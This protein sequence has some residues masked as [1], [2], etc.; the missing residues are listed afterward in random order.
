MRRMNDTR[1]GFSL[2]ELLL[3]IFILGIGIISVAAIFPAGIAQQVQSR[4]DLLGP[5][6]AAQAMS[7]IRANVGQED[8]GTFEQFGLSEGD[9]RTHLPG[10]AQSTIPGDW[11][12]MRPSFLLA[13]ATVGVPPTLDSDPDPLHGAIDIFGVR[14]TRESEGF[15]DL[16]E[17]SNEDD[18][19]AY[20]TTSDL[21]SLT[22]GNINGNVGGAQRS[23]DPFFPPFDSVNEPGS[24]WGIPFNRS[25]YSILSDPNPSLGQGNVPPDHRVN[26]LRRG[27][28]EPL[29]TITQGERAWP[30]GA[31][32]PEYYWDCLFRRYQGR[33]QI[34]IFVYRVGF[35]GQEAKPYTVAAHTSANNPTGFWQHESPVPVRIDFAEE[36]RWLPTGANP[37]SPLDDLAIPGTEPDGAVLA[38]ALDPYTDGWQFPGQWIL[39]QH[40]NVHR[41]YKGRRS[42][43]DGPVRLAQ[44]VPYMPQQAASGN[45]FDSN[46]DLIEDPSEASAVK[47]IWFVPPETRDGVFLTPVF[48]MVKDL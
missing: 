42:P 2:V 5:V 14:R 18:E 11:G 8:F 21:A 28:A 4:D 29:R 10:D 30:Q 24:L 39:D 46:F 9:A 19:N 47:S 1:R 36:D 3:S 25:R 22:T 45:L 38:P 26:P 15:S 34:A 7:T 17:T 16:Q 43:A 27:R 20:I 13:P 31:E 6:V 40:G 23:T 44:A 35:G 33:V 12:W 41:V 48:V 32:R 37:D